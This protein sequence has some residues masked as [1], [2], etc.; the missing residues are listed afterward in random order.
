MPAAL[1]VDVWFMHLV[2]CAVCQQGRPLSGRKYIST[3]WLAFV[4]HHP[5]LFGCVYTVEALIVVMAASVQ[6]S[7]LG[8]LKSILR[9]L[10]ECV[11]DSAIVTTPAPA[12]VPGGAGKPPPSSSGGAPP[13]ASLLPPGAVSSRL[14]PAQRAAITSQRRMDLVALWSTAL[15]TVDYLHEERLVLSVLFE[16]SAGKPARLRQVRFGL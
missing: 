5:S 11:Q 16:Q 9:T 6:V 1:W 8:G 13:P 7:R 14:T 15:T 3:G 4:E 12:A 2:P 10:T